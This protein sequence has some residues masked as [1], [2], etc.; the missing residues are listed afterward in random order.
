MKFSPVVNHKSVVNW[1]NNFGP[2]TTDMSA[3]PLFVSKLWERLAP[4]LFEIS[5]KNFFWWGSR[6]I[7]VT[8]WQELQISPKK[9]RFEIFGTS[10]P[11]EPSSPWPMIQ[12]YINFSPHQTVWYFDC[13]TNQY[14]ARK[15]VIFLNDIWMWQLI[16]CCQRGTI[17]FPNNHR[18][19]G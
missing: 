2:R 13:W 4:V 1:W 5:Q 7:S 8:Q 15:L 10:A 14:S 9:W 18:C 12:R 17:L 19:P 6:P 16:I 11:S 3:I